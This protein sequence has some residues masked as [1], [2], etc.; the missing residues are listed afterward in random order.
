MG[1]QNWWHTTRAEKRAVS[2]LPDRIWD[3]P[4]VAPQ[5]PVCAAPTVCLTFNE[6][7]ATF[8]SGAIA[9]LLDMRHWV[10]DTDEHYRISQ[11]LE[12]IIEQMEFGCNEQTS[13]PSYGES[14]SLLQDITN[15]Y[16]GT[17]ESVHPLAP[18]TTFD[19]DTDDTPTQAAC[20]HNTLCRAAEIVVR[21]A[22]SMELSRRQTAASWTGM[23]AYLPTIMLAL[24]PNPITWVAFAA[25]MLAWGVNA[26]AKAFT[27]VSDAQLND[28]CAQ[29]P[30][31]CCLTD[32]LTGLAPTYENFRTGLDNC[33]GLTG[34]A[35]EICNSI[36][37]LLDD[38][39]LFLIFLAAL[40]TAQADCLFGRV[41][42]CGCDVYCNLFDFLLD[43]YIF[44]ASCPKC[45]NWQLGSGW[46]HEDDDPLGLAWQR[47][48][49]INSFH[50][51][52]NIR[53][54][55]IH[56]LYT[57][58][59]FEGAGQPPALRVKLGANDLINIPRANMPD[60]DQWFA[61]TGNLTGNSLQADLVAS[62]DNSTPKTFA[63]SATI[64]A[65]EVHG[66]GLN[67]F[68]NCNNCLPVLILD[69]P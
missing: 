50:A 21:A 43:D 40:G 51:S 6:E 5:T 54:V 52:V 18:G 35:L 64:L 20:R 1:R 39:T 38:Y 19:S 22:C 46:L 12:R 48:V 61:W 28:P 16:N 15:G 47:S 32:N 2:R 60:G 14:V 41:G 69:C 36:G 62:Y 45:G 11:A 53:H 33:C 34:D 65:L 8:I 23:S 63:G 9:T 59:H 24:V 25:G 42:G 17:P 31:A 56:V 57:G 58:G 13:V 3:K 68:G 67:P 26:L 10:G 44:G 55:R 29:F 66:C 37:Y 30:V 7:W 27:E 49:R 4:I